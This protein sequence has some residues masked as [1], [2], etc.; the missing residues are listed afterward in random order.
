MKIAA[1]YSLTSSGPPVAVERGV[2]DAAPS[3]TV[4]AGDPF[5]IY[6]TSPG[7]SRTLGGMPAVF[8]SMSV[9]GQHRW[10]F[11]LAISR[12]SGLLH[13]DGNGHVVKRPLGLTVTLRRAAW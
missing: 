1:W 8:A 13:H 7:W 5:R 3:F 4:A 10:H 6:P 9:G 11:I 2:L 12:I